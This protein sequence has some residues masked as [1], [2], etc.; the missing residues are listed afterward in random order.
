[1]FSLPVPKNSIPISLTVKPRLNS[2]C[3]ELATGLLSTLVHDVAHVACAKNKAD[4]WAD[5]ISAI[6]LCKLL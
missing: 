6:V 4:T 2:W 5:I 1:M 3:M